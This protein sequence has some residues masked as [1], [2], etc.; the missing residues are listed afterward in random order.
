M[1]PFHCSIGVLLGVVPPL[2]GSWYDPAAQALDAELAAV[3]FSVLKPAP[4]LGVATCSQ[5][6]PFH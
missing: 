4:G 3:P 2:S 1:V 5:R 6:V